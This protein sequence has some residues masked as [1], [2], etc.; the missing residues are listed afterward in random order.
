MS[1]K[2]SAASGIAA[3]VI[4][5]AVLLGWAVNSTTLISIHPRFIAMLPITA[6][7]ALLAGSAIVYLQRGRSNRTIALARGVAAFVVTVAAL[8][9]ASRAMGQAIGFVD[10]L[11][12]DRVASHPYR[13]VGVMATNSGITFLLTGTALFLITSA[14]LRAR[15]VGRMLATIGLSVAGVALLGHLYGA[16]ALFMVDRYAGMALLTAIAFAALNLGVLFLFPTDSGISLV[17]SQDLTAELMRRLLAWTVMLPVILGFLWIEARRASLLSRETG[18]AVFVVVTTGCIAA[19][20]L[21]SARFLRHTD[22]ERNE[23]LL[24]E[25]EARATAEQANRAKSDFLA[26]MSHELRTPLN[27]IV[28]YVALLAEEIPGPVTPAQAHNLARIRDNALHL[29]NVVDEVLTLA[30][31]ESGKEVLR[32]EPVK[33]ELLLQD[34]AAALEPLARAKGLVFHYS[35]E[36][37]VTIESDAHRLRQILINL[38][39]NAVKFTHRGSVRMRARLRG[40]VL[41]I[42]VTD[43][44]IGIA[45]Q[46]RDRIFDAFL[47]V[48]R[49]HTRKY[50]GSGL[51]LSV[52]RKLARL[53]GGDITVDSREGEGSTFTLSI[54]AVLSPSAVDEPAVAG[55]NMSVDTLQEPR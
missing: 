51:G 6:L 2:T 35:C 54:S 41:I 14:S 8:S 22:R 21:Y 52:S 19:M 32:R 5:I 50:G 16:P 9:L 55:H 42:D 29:T 26:V 10:V 1:S 33:V 44:G 3:C 18:V 7:T 28:G 36:T 24:R 31:V 38:G 13:P 53:L 27:A 43:T 34:A 17:T 15:R 23:V 40:D 12:R 4:G 47:Q 25:R 48:E 11:F 39:G 49:P 45:P 20:L 30:R 46:H 37:P